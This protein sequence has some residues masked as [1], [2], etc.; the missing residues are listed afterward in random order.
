MPK[1]KSTIDPSTQVGSL[2]PATVIVQPADNV[3]DLTVG[4]N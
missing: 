4:P 2:D 3:D 1:K